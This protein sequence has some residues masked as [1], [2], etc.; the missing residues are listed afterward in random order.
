METKPD[1]ENQINKA[2]HSVKNLEPV[3]LPF[4]FT[5]KVMNKLHAE[6][7][8]VRSLFALS[9]MLKIAAMITIILVNIYTLNLELSSNTPPPSTTAQYAG[10]N[11]FVSYYAINDANYEL[12][13]INKPVHE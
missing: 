11:D 3:E 2:F 10:I 4:G 7:N 12:V 1:I 9:P 13:T 8:N 6:K 5:D